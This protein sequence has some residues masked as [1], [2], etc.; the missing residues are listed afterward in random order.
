MVDSDPAEV[1]LM[2]GDGRLSCPDCA[3]SLA[4]WGHAR[5]RGIR[6]LAGVVTRLRPRR[7]R[8]P[9]CGRTHVLL[10]CW[11]LARRADSVE[12]IGA[13]L[14]AKASGRGYRPIAVGLNVAECTV[15]GWLRRFAVR[16]QSWREAF[17]TLLMVL[18][19]EPGPV[20][21]CGSV[22]ADAVTVIGLAAAAA[23]RRFGPKSP[24]EFVAVVST[25]S[26]LGPIPVG[27][28]NGGLRW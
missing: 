24:W 22:F 28:T 4:P 26:L 13:A 25:G 11:L 6:G 5:V 18:D 21:A 9:D 19:P 1:E 10:A 15:R 20:G 3:G 12:V 27:D 16:A 7:S 23:T 2:L 8:C 14:S 17:T